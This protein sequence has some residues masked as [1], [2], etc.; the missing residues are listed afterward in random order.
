MALPRLFIS[1]DMQMIT[2][3]NSID[4]DKDDVQSLVHALMYQDKFDIVGIASSVSR[5]QPGKN[6]DS[7]IHHVIDKYAENRDEL[8]ARADGFKTAAELHDITYQ[9]TKWLSGWSG[10]PGQTDASRAIV[11]EAREARDAGAPLYVATWGGVGDVAQALHDAPDIAGTVRLLSVAGQLQEPNAH[12]YLKREF[13]GQ[14]ELWW[15][16]EATTH[17]GVY[18]TPDTKTPAGN[19]W[20]EANARGHGTLG[21]FFYEN[22]LDVRGTGGTHDGMKMGDSHTTLYLIDGAGN[23]D[24]PTAPSWG[25]QFREAGDRYWVDQAGQAFN[26]AGSGGARTTYEDRAA[27]TGDFAARLDWLQSAP[28]VTAPVKSP[29]TAPV[30]PPAPAPANATLGSGGDTLVLKLSQDAWQG[31][32]QYIISVDGRQTGGTQTAKSLQAS[33]QD[34]TVIVKGDWAAGAHKVTV[35]FLNDAWG[36][37][38]ATDRNLHVEGITY[39]GAALEQGSAELLRNGSVDFGF[40]DRGMAAT[41]DML[42]A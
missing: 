39:N 8:A 7:F 12:A 35:T 10:V 14:G 26:F 22:T 11:R 28:P 19:A 37:T 24:D 4:G 29:V 3:I 32:A 21:Q 17:F 33:G 1:T 18:A 41:A 2:G 42:F 30:V 16:D 13:A 6:D 40:T 38:A 27:W 25:G 31:S 9:G 34:D 15:I 23:N 20:A 5:W 36:G